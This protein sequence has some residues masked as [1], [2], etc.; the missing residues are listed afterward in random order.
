MELSNNKELFL[1]EHLLKQSNITRCRNEEL[2]HDLNVSIRTMR[3][4]FYK[5]N[6]LK[7]LLFKFLFYIFLLFISSNNLDILSKFSLFIPYLVIVS[8][9]VYFIL[10]RFFFLLALIKKQCWEVVFRILNTTVK[11]LYFSV[12]GGCIQFFIIMNSCLILNSFISSDL[13]Y[14][15]VLKPEWMTLL[16]VFWG[17][18]SSIFMVSKLKAFLSRNHWK[19]EELQLLESDVIPFYFLFTIYSCAIFI[20]LVNILRAEVNTENLYY[21]T[22]LLINSIGFLVLCSAI[23]ISRFDHEVYKRYNNKYKVILSMLPYKN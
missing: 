20:N 19:W 11:I 21:F 22:I 18:P 9:I 1:I 4:K 10:Q 5:K 14:Q 23:F 16:V 17:V 13:I 7:L 6:A 2:K 8:G 3:E 15:M 12:L